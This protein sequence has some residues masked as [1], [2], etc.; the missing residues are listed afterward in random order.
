VLR[1]L[2]P[3]VTE[4]QRI[5]T[6]DDLPLPQSVD[7][8]AVMILD[9]G[10]T[11]LYE[12]AHR[13][14]PGGAFEEYASPFGG[15]PVVYVIR[16]SQEDV[17][18]LQG[19]LGYYRKGDDLAASPFLI[20][21]ESQLHFDWPG[22][23][24][25]E[26]PFLVEWRGVLR[27]PEYGAYRLVLRAPA[28]AELYLDDSLLLR[29]KGE[30]F[31]EVVLARGN[32]DLRVKTSGAEGRFELAW[33]PPGGEEQVVPPSALYAPPVTANGLLGWYFPNG[34]WEPPLAFARIDPRLGFYYHIPP[35][36]MPYTVEWEGSI[37]IPQSG[38]YV[39]AIQS[40]D[41]SALYIDGQ[42]VVASPRRSEYDQVTLGLRAGRHDL[43]VRYAARTDHM[44][45]NLYWTPPG[46][47]REILPPQVLLPPRGSWQ[48]LAASAG[49]E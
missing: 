15:P 42:E 4:Y 17:S 7:R 48:L 2:V 9:G 22:D 21:Q 26:P 6:H 31:T 13:Y 27:A 20:R 45:L 46:G 47:T 11:H 43:R 32:H 49:K 30:S 12:E 38:K 34:D 40:T 8:D 16:L 28:S 10:S 36:P 35:L 5:E 19:L 1:F 14:Y 3:E 44:Y 33:Q 23:V 41:E 24:P 25:L 39:F 18:R 29:G 37:L